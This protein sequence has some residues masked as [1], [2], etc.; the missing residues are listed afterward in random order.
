MNNNNQYQFS[1]KSLELILK[2]NLVITVQGIQDCYNYQ[3]SIIKYI[4]HN[5]KCH[6]FGY[7]QSIREMAESLLRLIE[8]KQIPDYILEQFTEFLISQ[9]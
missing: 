7:S 3:Q 1:I 9:L 5:T 8:E 2:H 4:K 6:F